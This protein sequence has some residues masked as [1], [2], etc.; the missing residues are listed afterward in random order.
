VTRLLL[1]R[2]GLTDWNA[3]QRFQ[4]Q[5]DIPLNATGRLQAARLGR[6]LA[7]Q[8]LQAIFCSDLQR[9]RS[10]AAAVAEVTQALTRQAPLIY[11]EPDLREMSFGGWEGM[12]FAEIERSDPERLVAW[13]ADLLRV[14]PPG[15][16]TLQQVVD[17]VQAALERVLAPAIEGDYLIVAHGGPLQILVC[18]ALGLPPDRYWQFYLSP[19]SLS[20]ISFYPAG[21]ILNRLND[22]GHLGGLPKASEQ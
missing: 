20:E 12:T 17:R 4:G 10:T 18:L 5:A 13:Q 2:H 15:G 8:Q 14:A 11:P 22:T 6:R 21:A 7:G 19:A 1:A 3:S 16:E 9:A